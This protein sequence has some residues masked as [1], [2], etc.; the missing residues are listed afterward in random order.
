VL[1]LRAS[2]AGA[3]EPVLSPQQRH[4]LATCLGTGGFVPPLARLGPFELACWAVRS[5]GLT[6]SVQRWRVPGP[7]PDLF[8]LSAVVPPGDAPFLRPS[9]A[10]WAAR[11]GLDP[12][13]GLAPIADRAAALL[14]GFIG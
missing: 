2:G 1:R 3:G 13:P 11:R 14:R 8:E 5:G 10:A 9:F 6:L 7:G 4:L 12:A